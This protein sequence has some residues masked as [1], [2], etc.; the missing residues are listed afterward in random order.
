[1]ARDIPPV[2]WRSCPE[3]GYEINSAEIICPSCG[4]AIPYA[5]PSVAASQLYVEARQ[6][7]RPGKRMW[8]GAIIGVLAGF[9]Q[10]YFGQ[11]LFHHNRSLG[12]GVITANFVI[13][14]LIAG[15]LGSFY[16]RSVRP[17]SGDLFGYSSL[18]AFLLLVAL[19]I[20]NVNG[21]L[22]GAAMAWLVVIL[23][24]YYVVPMMLITT[25][26]VWGGSQLGMLLF[27]APK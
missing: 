23:S 10:M 2:S 8:L 12:N 11:W 17:L 27:K 26:V 21:L 9:A 19:F 24:I 15:I 4:H 6:K 3:C 14:P 7:P 5:S 16:W 22:G 13:V 20:L 25:L 1:M 18:T